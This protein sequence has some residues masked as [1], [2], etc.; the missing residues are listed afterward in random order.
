MLTTAPAFRQ[1]LDGWTGM[2]GRTVQHVAYRGS[3][4][5]QSRSLNHLLMEAFQ[6]HS[7]DF[8]SLDTSD[9]THKIT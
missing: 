9:F 1:L 6:R 8:K 7:K 4:V 5:H 3:E 2:W